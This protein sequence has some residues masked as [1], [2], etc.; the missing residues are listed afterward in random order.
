MSDRYDSR[1]LLPDRLVALEATGSVVTFNRDGLILF[2]KSGATTTSAT[3]GAWSALTPGL[4]FIVDNSNGSGALT[5]VPASGTTHVFA[6]GKVY[7]CL[8]CAAGT[9]KATELA[10]GPT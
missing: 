7:A 8:V 10:T 4:A 6:A 5:I 1:A 9:I 3:C 2:A